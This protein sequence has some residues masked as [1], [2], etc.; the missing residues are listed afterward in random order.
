MIPLTA[1]NYAANVHNRSQETPDLD[2]IKRYEAKA[3]SETILHK[4]GMVTAKGNMIGFGMFVMGAWDPVLKPGYAEVTI[5]VDSK[6]QSHGI[7]SR[8]LDEIEILA[9][10]HGADSLQTSIKDTDERS[11]DWA[12]KRGFSI[13]SQTFES[14][15][16]ITEFDTSQFDASFKAL[17]SAGIRFTSLAEYPQD[18]VSHNRF[19]NF[20]R[21]LVSDIPGMADQPLPDNDRMNQLTQDV[22]KNGFILAVDGHQWIA[23]SMIIKETDTTY[24]NS[25][26]GVSRKYRGSGLAQAIKVKAIDYALQNGATYIRTHNDSKNAPMLSLNEKLGYRQKPG[27]FSLVKHFN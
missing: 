5:N 18:E 6:W 21:E 9:E 13:T 3:D 19:W 2:A 14:Q 22:D 7:G 8:M 15:L 23:L 10:R 12:K 16:S 24:Y 26:T 4:F 17:N 11:L 20:W 1:S 27:Q 25:M